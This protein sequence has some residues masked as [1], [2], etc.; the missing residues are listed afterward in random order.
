M[1]FS[2]NSIGVISDFKIG[3]AQATI[4]VESCAKHIF[5]CDK[6]RNCMGLQTF[7]MLVYQYHLQLSCKKLSCL[8][9]AKRFVDKHKRHFFLQMVLWE[10]KS[11]L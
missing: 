2:S 9:C 1:I 5:V 3:T 8:I 6:K 7:G 4:P 11:Q 10:R